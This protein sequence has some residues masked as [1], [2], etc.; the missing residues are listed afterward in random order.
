MPSW[1]LFDAQNPEYRESVLPSSVRKR[2]AVEAGCSMGWHK[3]I[4]DGT[5]I[6]IDHFGASAPGDLLMKNFGFTAEHVTAAALALM[7]VSK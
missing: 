3:W 2:V 1:N 4:A 7:G 5:V 6:A